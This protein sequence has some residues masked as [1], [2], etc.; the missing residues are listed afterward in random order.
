M[1]PLHVSFSLSLFVQLSLRIK[2]RW[3]AIS[4]SCWKTLKSSSRK[5]QS[6]WETGAVNRRNWHFK[7]NRLTSPDSPPLPLSHPSHIPLTSLSHPV[8]CESIC[9]SRSCQQSRI[10][11]GG[12]QRE[13]ERKD[14]GLCHWTGDCAIVYLPWL[15]LTAEYVRYNIWW[16]PSPT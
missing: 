13:D 4:S 10:E 1:L 14:R 3:K 7:K 12:L 6:P 5:H 9:L 2:D 8:P 11:C 16:R 15:V